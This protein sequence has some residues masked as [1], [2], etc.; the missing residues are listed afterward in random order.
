MAIYRCEA[1]GA[2]LKIHEGSTVCVCEYCGTYQSIPTVPEEE[3]D[4][5]K[6]RAH[7]RKGELED[8]IQNELEQWSE[9]PDR[10]SKAELENA[11]ENVYRKNCGN[12]DED[13]AL[14][15]L[16]IL[17]SESPFS[18]ASGITYRFY[19]GDDVKYIVYEQKHKI[20]PFIVRKNVNMLG[21]DWYCWDDPQCRKQPTDRCEINLD[22]TGT[23]PIHVKAKPRG[24]SS[25]KLYI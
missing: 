17:T 25:L 1:C 3:Y 15:F 18:F 6:E 19:A 7:T 8:Y 10:M 21:V 20:V 9:K 16:E 23:E 11:L 2:N 5:T 24:L 14:I 13:N 4:P 12:I 22:V